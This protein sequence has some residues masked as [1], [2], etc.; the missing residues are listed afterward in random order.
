MFSSSGCHQTDAID[1]RTG[2]P[3]WHY[4]ES[5]TGGG[6]GRTAFGDG[7]LFV[8]DNENV[9]GLDASTGKKIAGLDGR[10]FWAPSLANGLAVAQ[11]FAPTTNELRAYD[12]R[13]GVTQWSTALEAQPELPVLITPGYAFALLGSQIDA[14]YLYAFD[15]G[16]HKL[17]WKSAQPAVD[18]DKGWVSRGGEPFQGMAAAGGRIV[19]AYQRT[20]TAFASM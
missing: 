15:L 1:A 10:L 9:I 12:I 13:T 14:S 18:Y 2:A 5:C 16:T 4:V 11:H 7:V 19:V 3:Q 6:G 8:D 20:L 17:A